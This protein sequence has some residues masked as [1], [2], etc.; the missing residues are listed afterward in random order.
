MATADPNHTRRRSADLRPMI[1]AA[2]EH[3]FS[4]FGYK[5]ATMAAIA[6]RAEVTRSVLTRHFPTKANLFAEVITNPL[7]QFVDEWTQRWTRRLGGQPSEPELV[8]EFISDLYHNSRTHLGSL[9]LLMFSQEHLEPVVR[10]EVLT[11]INV[12]LSAVLDIANREIDSHGY[13]TRHVDV[14]VRAIIAM[15]LGYLA[16]DPAL[17]TPTADEDAVVSHLSALILY[18][19]ALEP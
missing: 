2:A 16:L 5:G 3:T 11:K 6:A 14:T 13:P 19:L 9:R 7:L 1:V 8:R 10:Q 18:G 17:L 4:Q 15:V 12:G